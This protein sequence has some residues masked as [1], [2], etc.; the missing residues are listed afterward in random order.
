M[1]CWV[2]G[3][4][5]KICWNRK[6]RCC[7][8]CGFWNHMNSL[9]GHLIFSKMLK[10]S[11]AYLPLLTCSYIELMQDEYGS[12]QR[13][14]SVIK[15]PCWFLN[16]APSW[17]WPQAPFLLWIFF[18]FKETSLTGLTSP[19]NRSSLAIES[20]LSHI[21]YQSSD[22]SWWES[23]E[24]WVILKL[25]AGLSKGLEWNELSLGSC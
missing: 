13:R 19:W 7:A 5:S 3:C 21:S 14:C 16:Q 18:F 9:L 12:T 22:A 15:R 24:G 11:V 23:R 6:W 25:G 8:K 1:G 4:L 20:T 10:L 17:E 2:Q